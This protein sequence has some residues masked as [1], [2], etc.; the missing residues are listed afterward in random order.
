MLNPVM[1]NFQIQFGKNFFP[2]E[3]IEK[4]D[5]W[6]YSRNYPLKSMEAYIHET[7]KNVSIPGEQFQTLLVSAMPNLRNTNFANPSINKPQG[8]PHTTINR[9]YPGTSS[10][11]DIVDG[12]TITV[13]YKNTIIN[14]IYIFEWL[15][16]YYRRTRLANEFNFHLIM[17]DSARIP[18]IDFFVDDVFV[19]GMPGLEFSYNS[20]FSE[21]LTF[22]VTY[23]FN[24]F[25]IDLIVPGFDIET[26]ILK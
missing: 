13:T 10:Y 21:S 12:I 18:M 2:K 20:S 24:R 1:S 15:Y 22:D 19:S 3:I 4:Y 7:I 9:S 11:N 8:F 14:W 5:N 17:L 26:L 6:L 23:T 16:K 25:N